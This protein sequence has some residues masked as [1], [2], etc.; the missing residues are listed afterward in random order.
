MDKEISKA[1]R[2]LPLALT[3]DGLLV[4][5]IGGPIWA[6]LHIQG[7]EAWAA[8]LWWW[9]WVAAVMVGLVLWYGICEDRELIGLVAEA[10]RMILYMLILLVTAWWWYPQVRAY[11]EGEGH[12]EE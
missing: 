4:L 2:H 1:M 7:D 3:V 12:A 11:E 9:P 6:T 10:P 5:L 8:W